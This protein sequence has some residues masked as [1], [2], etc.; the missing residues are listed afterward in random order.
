MATFIPVA[1]PTA[2][3]EIKPQM[4]AILAAA[5]AAY[6]YDPSSIISIRR[7]EGKTWALAGRLASTNGRQVMF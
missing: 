5:V 3:K 7:V 2:A 4:A 1:P 6:G